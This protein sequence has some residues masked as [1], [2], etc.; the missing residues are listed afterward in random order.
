MLRYEVAKNIVKKLG[1]YV[2]QKMKLL[3]ALFGTQK[4]LGKGKKIL[5]KMIFSCLVSRGKYK[6]KLN[7]IKIRQN[8]T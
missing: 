1:V 6:R 5:K 2:P 7:I 4:V 3:Q 8:F